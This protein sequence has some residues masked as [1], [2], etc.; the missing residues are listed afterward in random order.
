MPALGESVAR[1]RV[2]WPLVALVVVPTVLLASLGLAGLKN[3]RDADEARLRERYLLQSRAIEQGILT[4]LAEEDQRLREVLAPVPGPDVPGALSRMTGG[5][6]DAAW[7]DDD[8]TAPEAVRDALAR[9][10]LGAELTFVAVDEGDGLDIVALSRVR[11]DLSIAYRLDIRTV[12]AVVLPGLVGRTFPNEAA[13]Y[14]V[15]PAVRAPAA[16]PV[17]LETMRRTVSEALG[18]EPEV[19]RAMAPPFEH[20]RIVIAATAPAG[21]ASGARTVTLVVLLTASAVAG[22]TLMG[23]A[24][25]QQVR[26]S[27]LQT[28]FVSNVSHELRTPLTSIRLFIETLQSGRVTDPEKVKECL[29][30]I[31]AESERLSAKVERVLAWAR[32]ESGRRLWEMRPEAPR[33]LVDAALDAF[34]A[35]HLDRPADLTVEVPRDLPLVLADRDG[36]AEALLNLLSNA[37]KYGGPEVPIRVEARAERRHVAITVADGGPGIPASERERIFEKFYRPDILQSRRT[38]GSGLGLA[39]VKAI[40]VAHQGRVDVESEPGRGAR[41]TI[42]LRRAA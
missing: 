36:I 24:M 39:I 4:R 25:V 31:A 11:P 35:Q 7:T 19:D 40:V 21:Q 6:F 29:D 34:R 20:W 10:D 14:H 33:A 5:L 13:T 3:Q 22:V 28:D 30:V 2:F 18:A 17:S 26:L 15:T 37:L 1:R 42:R 9:G 32:L 12:D 27:R 41:F 8:P 38:Q 16:E 23:R